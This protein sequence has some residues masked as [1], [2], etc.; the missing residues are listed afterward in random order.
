[1]KKIGVLTLTFNNYGTR[2]QAYALARVLKGLLNGVAEVEVI[3]TEECWKPTLTSLGI[4]KIVHDTLKSYGIWAWEHFI[5]MFR[6]KYERRIMY[7]CSCHPGK[8]RRN[9]KFA[10]ICQEIPYTRMYSYNEIRGGCLSNYDSII[11]GSDQVWNAL[12]V[13]N[14]DVYMLAFTNKKKGLSYAASF[15]ITNIPSKIFDEYKR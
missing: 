14:L 4:K 5:Y 11:V 7:R 1:M 8:E 3:N 2:L 15:G 6:W 10:S 12:K 13:G 9:K